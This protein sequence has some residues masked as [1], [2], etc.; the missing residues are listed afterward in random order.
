[1]A[2]YGAKDSSGNFYFKALGDG[3]IKLGNTSDD[4]I[5]VTGTLDV[6]GDVNFDGGAV[7]NESGAQTKDFRVESL[8]NT[9]MFFIDA[10]TNRIGIGNNSPQTVLDIRDPFE[11]TGAEKDAVI[12]L[13]SRRD[14]GIKLIAD[15]ANTTGETDNPFIDY[16]ADSLSDAS[17]RSN[18]LASMALEGPAG[19]TFTDSIAG[20]YFLDAFCPNHTPS[21]LRPFQIANDSSN[22]GHKARI[23]IEGTNGYVGI[24]TNTPSH[25]LEVDGAIKAIT[26]I[27]APTT[28][29]LGS[30]KT[31]TLSI[32]SSLMFLDADS[33]TGQ[34]LGIG[35]DVHTLNIP[36][37]TTSGQRLTL[38]IEGNMGTG[39]SVAIM[40]AGNLAGASDM[41]MPNAKTSL[42]FVYYSTASISAWYQV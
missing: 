4:L 3:E 11:G 27:T 42:N 32:G 24:W 36:N 15:T 12:R 20:A 28:Q 39:N 16:Y 5:H 21:H 9:H 37:G 30:G 14:V 22:N 10:G 19:T 33:I 35:M 1:M 13:R 38:V 23:T 41:F 25:P 8:N 7:F 2:G 18:R 6:D 34:D 29:D 40:V 31:S 26:N 17:G